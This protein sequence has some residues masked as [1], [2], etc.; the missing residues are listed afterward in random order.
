MQRNKS[1]IARFAL[2]ELRR[3][4]RREEIAF[5]I[6]PRQ[7]GKTTI[8]QILQGELDAA[9]EKTVFLSLD[10]DDDRVFFDSQQ[11]L[12]RKI[13]L[14]IGREPGYVFIDEVQ[15]LQDAG[16]FLK[17]LQDRK[18]PY[19]FIVSGSGSV[20]LKAK[21]KESMVGRKRV[22]EVFPL[23]LREFV[24]HRTGYQYSDRLGD[25]MAVEKARADELMLEYMNFG[26]YPSVVL[27]PEAREKARV[28]DEIYEGLYPEGH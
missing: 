15:R 22:Y 17:G 7:A 10:Y 23:S 12:L 27:E 2:E 20:D 26:G 25:F 6:G 14:E 28:M 8:M 3:D 4:I 5:L 13:E 18:T 9:G 19:K 21:V 24:D 1:Y 11:G 16:V